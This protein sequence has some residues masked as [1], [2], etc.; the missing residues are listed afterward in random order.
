MRLKGQHGSTAWHWTPCSSGHL[1]EVLAGL[2][3]G[4]EALLEYE[5]TGASTETQYS[6]TTWVQSLCEVRWCWLLPGQ[7][8]DEQWEALGDHS[9]RQI[10]PGYINYSCNILFILL[11]YLISIVNLKVSHCQRPPETTG[12]RDMKA[13]LFAPTSYHSTWIIKVGVLKFEQSTTLVDLNCWL[14]ISN[15]Q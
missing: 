8:K 11:I 3:E 6:S 1:S 14:T 15:W 12:A 13:F 5:P 10:L 2:E 7:L 9:L 4:R